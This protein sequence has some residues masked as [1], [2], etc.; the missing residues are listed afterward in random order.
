MAT[1]SSQAAEDNIVAARAS[2]EHE[3]GRNLVS[4]RCLRLQSG[5]DV[6]EDRVSAAFRAVQFSGAAVVTVVDEQPSLE[7]KMVRPVWIFA[8]REE[9]HVSETPVFAS[10]VPEAAT[11][12]ALEHRVKRLSGKIRSAFIDGVDEQIG[13]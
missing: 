4:T 3:E 9:H 11:D 12:A 13:V 5:E 1:G 6:T 10:L 8:G 7:I 2:S